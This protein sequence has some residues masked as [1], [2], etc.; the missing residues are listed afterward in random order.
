MIAGIDLGGSQVRVAVAQA[1]GRILATMRTR[2]PLLRT[3]E[4]VAAWAAE[5]V[6]A[7]AGGEPVAVVAIGAPGPIDPGR[8]TLVNPPNLPR[9][10]NVP[11]ARLLGDRLGCPVHLEND[12]N[13]AA[14][15]EFEQGAG[16]G[17]RTMVYVTWSTGV[18]AGLVLDGEL[19]SGAHGSAG[20]VGHMILDVD[21]PLDACGQR[22]CVEAL[23]SGRALEAQTGTPAKV[24]FERAAAGDGAAAAVVLRAT[25]SMGQ[26]LISLANLV[27]PELIVVGGGISRSWRQV[28]PVL[29]QVLRSSPFIRP[30]RRPRIRRAR[31]G[32]RAGQVGA[33][34]WARR[35]L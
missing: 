2:T 25:T 1:D 9:W 6:T 16:R 29:E 20:E 8:G 21:G 23:C 10:R 31:L 28:R 34:E 26:A 15:G 7:L 35:R 33:V 5:Q 30:Q 13:L 14:L 12:A 11:I 17:V 22:G 3:P 32:D 27:D 19:F 4:R 24:I 18:G